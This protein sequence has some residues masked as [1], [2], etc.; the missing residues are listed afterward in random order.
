MGNEPRCN[1]AFLVAEVQRAAGTYSELLLCGAL[2]CDKD[3]GHDGEHRFR[4]I[5]K[6]NASVKCPG[7]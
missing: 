6:G 4:E 3:A 7:T 1:A 5:V 2:Y